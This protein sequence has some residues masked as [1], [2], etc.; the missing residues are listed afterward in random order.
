METPYS[1]P[2]LLVI[3]NRPDTTSKVFKAIRQRKPKYLYIAA[4]GPRAEKAEEFE[5]CQ[6]ARSIVLNGVDWDC[7]IKTF[8]R[9]FNIGCGLNVSEAITWFF[10]HTEEGIILEDDCLPNASFFDFCQSLLERYRH[11]ER[12]SAISGNNFQTHQPMNLEADYYYSIFPSSWGWATW[13]RSWHDYNLFIED[14]DNIQKKEFL[15]FVFKEKSYQFWW[16][17]QFEYFFSQR[18]TDTWDFQFHFQTMRRKQLAVIPKANLISNIG[19]GPDGTHFHNPDS[20]F[21]KMPTYELTFPLK[22]PKSITRNYE[23][24]VF[25]QS[26]LFGEVEVPSIYKEMKRAIKKLIKYKV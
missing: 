12:V 19:H 4:D 21:A 9:E 23:A 11:D 16:K 10:N 25:V 6:E 14:W 24:D 15:T 17:N 1:V 5:K 26:L 13:R 3:F 22:H 8:F 20:Y 7:D 18:P 2:I